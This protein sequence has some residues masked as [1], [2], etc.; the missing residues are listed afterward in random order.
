MHRSPGRAR[1]FTLIEVLIV[2]A[3]IGILAGLAVPA[4][5]GAKRQS[6]IRAA[7]A[8]L[9][10]L[11][12]ALEVYNTR[13]GD[14]PPS[15]LAAYGVKVN[16]T[17]N[18]VESLVACLQST[19]KNGPFG[20]WKEERYV[21]LDEDD[22]GKNLTSWWF[23]DTQLRELADDWGN[24]YVY[25]HC[26]DYAQPDAA[27]QYTVNGATVETAPGKSEKTKAYHNPRTYQ[28]WSCGPDETNQNGEEDDV[29][30]W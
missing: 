11:K 14:Y 30:A 20:D 4:L 10:G 9:S 8:D 3:I 22:A 5:V 1:G 15:S 6:R 27:A 2:I 28:I 25:Y 17:N 18:G 26:R 19:L 29:H 13:F 12:A 16:E 21:N 7:Q 23:G 24:P